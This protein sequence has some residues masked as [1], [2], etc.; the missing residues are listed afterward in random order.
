MLNFLMVYFALNILTY[1]V[2]LVVDTFVFHETRIADFGVGECILTLLIGFPLFIL[3]I[4]S[5]KKE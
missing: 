1:F 4:F 2:M 3:V 5:G